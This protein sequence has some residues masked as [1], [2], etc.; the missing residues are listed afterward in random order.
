MKNEKYQFFK[1]QKKKN[2]V[3]KVEYS[4]TKVDK[5]SKS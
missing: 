5:K 4:V 3:T 1:N 2:S